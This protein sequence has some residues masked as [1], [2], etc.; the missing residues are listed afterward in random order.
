MRFVCPAFYYGGELSELV[1]SSKAYSMKYGT[2]QKMT[3]MD[4]GKSFYYVSTLAESK[5]EK[6]G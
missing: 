5:K 6:Y 1:H 3:C 4:A 2:K